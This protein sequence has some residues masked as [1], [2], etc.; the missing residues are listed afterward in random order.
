MSASVSRPARAGRPS[1]FVWGRSTSRVGSTGLSLDLVGSLL[2]KTREAWPGLLV[3]NRQSTS[4]DISPS[5]RPG[6]VAKLTWVI[7]S[8]CWRR[9][10]DLLPTVRANAP[11]STGRPQAEAT[12]AAATVA[13]LVQLAPQSS[14]WQDTQTA[15]YC[16]RRCTILPRRQD[17]GK[18]RLSAWSALMLRFPTPSGG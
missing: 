2:R 1:D 11:T 12:T 13:N 7:S 8:S 15:K 9:S 6:H 14:A 17:Q 5:S 4:P 10:L 18:L 3:L 16:C